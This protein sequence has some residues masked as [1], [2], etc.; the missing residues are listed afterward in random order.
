MQTTFLRCTYKQKPVPAMREIENNN[1]IR[2][3]NEKA[4]ITYLDMAAKNI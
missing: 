4:V 2:T 1:A 3:C